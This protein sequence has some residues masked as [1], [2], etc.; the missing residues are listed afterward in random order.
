MNHFLRQAVSCCLSIKPHCLAYPDHLSADLGDG[1]VLS[2]SDVGKKRSV[3]GDG[4]V[5][6]A[7][8]VGTKFPA[9]C[10]WVTST[11]VLCLKALELLLG[12]KFVGLILLEMKSNIVRLSDL[13]HC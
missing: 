9:G 4:R 2:Q 13:Y 7:L 1:L 8:D 11:D 12:S 3:A 6:V 5:C 10:V